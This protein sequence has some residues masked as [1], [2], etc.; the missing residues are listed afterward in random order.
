M[1]RPRGKLA[2][3]LLAA[4]H[5]IKPIRYALL[6]TALLAGATGCSKKTNGTT[7][8]AQAPRVVAI[9]ADGDGFTPLQVKV[10]KGQ[11]VT[12]RFTRTS[13]ETCA[14]QVVFPDLGLKKD[15]PL[16]KP[17][18]IP[19]PSTKSRT[20]AFQCGMGMFKG[21]VVVN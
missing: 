4:T 1:P 15:L 2:Q 20:L 8:Q 17:V 7:A 13:D 16:N 14:K 9:T 11:T 3:S 12:L 10:A 21:S 19:V 18:D 6:S 5:M